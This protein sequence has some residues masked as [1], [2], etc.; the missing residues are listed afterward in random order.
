MKTNQISENHYNHI[1]QAL[2]DFY[3]YYL[4]KD[5]DNYHRFCSHWHQ[6]AEIKNLNP[7]IFTIYE[8]ATLF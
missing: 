1:D 3:K 4:T 7:E 6:I 2:E 5:Y 8:G